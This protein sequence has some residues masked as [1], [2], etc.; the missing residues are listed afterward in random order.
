MKSQ[1]LGLLALAL[2]GGSFAAAQDPGWYLGANVGQARSR[3]DNGQITSSLLGAGFT[4]TGF[5]EHERDLGYKVFA[6]YAFNRYFA[7]EGGYFNLGKF[8]FRADTLP[9]GT[10]DGRLKAQGAS[11]DGVVSLPFTDKFSAFGR[12]GVNYASVK[13]S[14]DGTG[15]VAITRPRLGKDRANY[16][17]GG[18]LQY[19]F[20]RSV[21]LRAELE[22][23]RISDPVGTKGD[24]D[25]A[26]LGLLVRFGRHAAVPAPAYVPPRA[27]VPAAVPAPAPPPPPPVR[28]QVYCSLLDLQFDIDSD[29]ILREDKE[30]LAVVGRFMTTYPATTA[31]IEG[32]TDNVGTSE[33][34]LKLSKGRADAVVAYLVDSLHIAPA[35][36]TA[37]GL[38]EA[39]PLASNDTEE[40][41]RQNRRIDAVI[42]CATDIEGLTVVPARITMAMVME[43]DEDRAE[44]RPEYDSELLKVATF[45]KANPRVTATV[46][47]HTANLKGDSARMAELS[48]LRALNVVDRLSTQFGIAR[49][50]LTAEGFSD[51]RRYAYNSTFAGQQENRRVNIIFNYPK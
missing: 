50:R 35:R 26:S 48:K 44:V 25:L 51:E 12:L 39:N 4:T 21:S 11:L 15:A 22:R 20:T 19:D 37:V 42:V 46:E 30:K 38:G 9:P 36:L 2:A 32:H 47:G 29:D 5:R 40:G 31:V 7:L 28:T 23:Y 10:L 16:T 18:G 27:E 8:D 34:N 49:D 14:F 3:I 33:H 17:F 24:L 1:C 41:K 13:D 45:L 43:F 6:G